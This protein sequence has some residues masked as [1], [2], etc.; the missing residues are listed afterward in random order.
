VTNFMARYVDNLKHQDCTIFCCCCCYLKFLSLLII[1]SLTLL[2]SFFRS[3]L[4][5]I[6]NLVFPSLLI[7]LLL[8]CVC[9]LIDVSGNHMTI[10]TYGSILFEVTIQG[11]NHDNMQ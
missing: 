4:S 6:A 5:F 2:G 8:Q 1:R 10:S 9:A 3:P 7:L 11:K